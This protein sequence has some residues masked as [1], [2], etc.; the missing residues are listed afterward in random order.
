MYADDTTRIVTYLNAR[1][2]SVDRQLL[3][4]LRG[5]AARGKAASAVVRQALAEHYGLERPTLPD[6]GVEALNAVTAQVAALV[7]T[8]AQ[9]QTQVATMQDQ[10]AKL[11]Q[12]THQLRL[13]LVGV[14]YG[15]RAM[16]QQGRAVASAALATLS[17]QSNGNGRA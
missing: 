9:L 16:Q 17:T 6:G 11:Q 1:R 8:V 12:Q 15:D 5:D 2:S 14:V 4:R 10:N 13:A 3:A 7:E